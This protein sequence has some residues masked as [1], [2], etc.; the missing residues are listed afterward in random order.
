MTS[1]PP[2]A[3]EHDPLQLRRHQPRRRCVVRQ[4]HVRVLERFAPLPKPKETH[5]TDAFPFPPP[6]AVTESTRTKSDEASNSQ[7]AAAKSKKTLSLADA[8]G[9]GAGVTLGVV[10]LVLAAL[11]YSGFAAFG[12]M[13]IEKRKWEAD[14]HVMGDRKSVSASELPFVEE[15][16]HH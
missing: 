15:T 6:L 5:S 10:A 16:V 13:A 8:G 7:V 1:P 3:Q 2:T 11:W 12:K 14:A 9:I 4:A